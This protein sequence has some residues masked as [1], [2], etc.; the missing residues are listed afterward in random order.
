MQIDPFQRII[1]NLHSSLF[2]LV[3]LILLPLPRSRAWVAGSKSAVRSNI[4]DRVFAERE[5]RTYVVWV[6]LRK[7]IAHK[8]PIRDAH[9]I[10]RGH[11]ILV[12]RLFDAL[13][14]PRL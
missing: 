3:N 10:K 14:F 12:Q 7:P 6:E 13:G 11:P 5:Q 1:A 2:S 4:E 8:A 9:R